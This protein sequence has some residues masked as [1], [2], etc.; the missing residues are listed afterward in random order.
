MKFRAFEPIDLKNSMNVLSVIHIPLSQI[1]PDPNQPRKNFQEHALEELARSIKQHGIIQPVILRQVE[2]GRYQIIA[3]ERRWRASKIAELE[4]IQAIIRTD[5]IE[6][7][8]AISLIENIQR[9][10]L[11]PIELAKAFHR[12]YQDYHLS[13]E[14][15]AEIVGKSRATVTN[16]LRLLN[17]AEEVQILLVN[18]KLEM[19]HAR[20]LLTLSSEKQILYAQRILEK[21]MT[22]RDAERLVQKYKRPKS[23]K[24]IP[25]SDEVN[26]W[27]KKLSSSLSSK[28]VIDINDEGQGQMIIHFAS[29]SE[30]EWLVHH[31]TNNIKLPEL[32]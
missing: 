14:A 32:E 29:K 1:F 23:E 17:L 11:N 27:L 30:A 12:L 18:N 3:G 15:I 6:E 20:A 4:E 28:V 13:H 16:V 31:V 19:G 7:D 22:V 9:E 5:K 21:N 26:L 2:V 25:Y 24:I 10:E 8:V